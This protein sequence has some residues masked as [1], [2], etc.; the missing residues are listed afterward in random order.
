MTQHVHALRSYLGELLGP[1][2]V[3]EIVI[4]QY[5]DNR[6]NYQFEG[7]NGPMTPQV[8]YQLLASV[9]NEVVQQIPPQEAPK[10]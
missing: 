3:N 5:E 8:V 4:T 7:L 10:A 9:A 2:P 1:R 6:I